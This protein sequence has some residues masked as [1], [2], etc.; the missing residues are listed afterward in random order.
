MQ[1]PERLDFIDINEF[2]VELGIVKS[3]IRDIWSEVG[4]DVKE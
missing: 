1:E 3:R 2:S 4:S